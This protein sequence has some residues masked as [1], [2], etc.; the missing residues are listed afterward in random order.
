MSPG[1]AIQEVIRQLELPRV[2][3]ISWRTVDLAPYGLYGIQA[4]YRDGRA[5]YYVLD[6]GHDLTVLAVDFWP[7]EG[8]S[9]AEDR[10]PA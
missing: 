8:R 3:F 5:R 1:L 7:N 10:Q 6:R 9:P 4:N 2:D